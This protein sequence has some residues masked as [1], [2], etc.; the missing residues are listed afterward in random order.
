MLGG[1]VGLGR[2]GGAIDAMDLHECVLEHK[3]VV[4]SQLGAQDWFVSGGRG[5]GRKPGEPN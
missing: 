2:G 5:G 4:I 1:G 3:A